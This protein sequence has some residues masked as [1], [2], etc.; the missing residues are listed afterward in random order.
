M[1][2]GEGRGWCHQ[3]KAVHHISGWPGDVACGEHLAAFTIRESLHVRRVLELKLVTVSHIHT[4]TH[5]ASGRQLRLDNWMVQK[6]GKGGT[7]SFCTGRASLMPFLCVVQTWVFQVTCFSV[8]TGGFLLTHTH[9]SS[10]ALS[11]QVWLW[12]PSLLTIILGVCSQIGHLTS[13]AVTD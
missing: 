7:S 10:L 12:V 9:T 5:L 13:G 1:C 11:P 6:P 3:A 8:F 2:Q 4:H